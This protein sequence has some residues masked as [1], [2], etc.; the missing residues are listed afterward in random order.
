MFVFQ[1]NSAGR[2]DAQFDSVDL[3]ISYRTRVV[4]TTQQD[5]TAAYAVDVRYRRLNSSYTVAISTDVDAN[6]DTYGSFAVE[7]NGEV[8]SDPARR[9]LLSDDIRI[10]QITDFLIAIA[11]ADFRLEFDVNARI[12]VLLGSLFGNKVGYSDQLLSFVS[13]FIHK[14]L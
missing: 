9:P 3:H 1:L 13:T 8:M 10:K 5:I 12:Y 2:Q 4:S 11:T 6:D 14:I 7:V